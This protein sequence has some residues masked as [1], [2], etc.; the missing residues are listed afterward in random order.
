[1]IHFNDAD[2]SADELCERLGIGR[3]AVVSALRELE[4]AGFIVNMTPDRPP[5]KSSW[6]ITCF[7]C[8]G[9][10]QTR[11]MTPLEQ[12]PITPYRIRRP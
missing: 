5:L 6:R 3:H 4:F 12:F 10:W 1:M 9:S 11:A 7:P 8:Q 2:V